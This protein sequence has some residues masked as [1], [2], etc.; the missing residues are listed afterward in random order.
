[1]VKLTGHT[2]KTLKPEQ[3]RILYERLKDISDKGWETIVEN[4][5]SDIKMI[6]SAFPTIGQIRA[7]WYAYKRANPS[8]YDYETEPCEYCRG[9]GIGYVIAKDENDLITKRLA[10]CIKC[11]NWK[12]LFGSDGIIQVSRDGVVIDTT[13]RDYPGKKLFVPFV[14]PEKRFKLGVMKKRFI[15]EQVRRIGEAI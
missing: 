11:R 4:F 15:G 6:P 8:K 2:G 13:T 1:L 3:V 5:I 12:K 7:S 14:V 10:F 9:T